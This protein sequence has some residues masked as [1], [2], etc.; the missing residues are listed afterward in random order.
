MVDEFTPPKFFASIR[1]MEHDQL[2]TK[3]NVGAALQMSLSVEV[4]MRDEYNVKEKRRLKSVVENQVELLKVREGE[5]ENLKAQLLLRETKAMEAI[6]LR[7]QAFNLKTIEKSLRDEVNALKERNSILEKERNALDV[8]VTELEASAVGK[9]RELTDLNAQ[10]TSVKS[11]NDNLMDQV[12]ELETSSS[13]LQEK[14]TVN[15]NCMEQLEKFQDD[16]MKVVNDKFDKLYTYFVEI[17]LH[18]EEKSYPHLLTTI[19][20]RRWLLTQ[21]MKLAITKC[22]N[23]PKYLSALRAAISKAI[24]KGMQDGLSV[25]ITHGKESRVLTDLAAH[26]PFAEVDYISALQQLQNV[27]FSLLAELKSNKDASIKT[28]MDILCLE[29]LLVEKLG[30]DKLQP[31]VDQ[32]MCLSP[33][34][35]ANQRSA[36]RDVF[37]PLAEPFSA[38]VLTGTEGTSDI[39]SATTNTTMT[40]FTT[41][42]STSS[43]APISV[44]DYEVIGADDQTVADGNAA[45]FPNVDDAELNIL[46]AFVI[47]YGPSH[48]GPSFPISSARL[49]SLL[50]S[51]FAVLSAG[52]SISAGMIAFVLYVNENGVSPFLD[53]IMVRCAHRT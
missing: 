10:I 7:A 8:K 30:L 26:N 16:Q 27:N 49:A 48:L 19:S 23:S 31:N 44:D 34:N 18:L 25:R 13:G 35:I 41:F 36:L 43:I 12:H 22:L 24:E 17:A 5:I 52:M 21:G 9:E 50:R 51:T 32:L 53:F 42:A 39:V 14:V 45:S 15:Q 38:A 6:R 11:Q 29:G 4:R 28:V 2:F 1:G 46:Y 20:G 37:V 40:L 3:F 47:S 33:E